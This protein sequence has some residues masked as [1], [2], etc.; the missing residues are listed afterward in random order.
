MREVTRRPKRPPIALYAAEAHA[1]EEQ[2]II[3]F[4]GSRDTAK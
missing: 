2:K 4:N 3:E 1:A